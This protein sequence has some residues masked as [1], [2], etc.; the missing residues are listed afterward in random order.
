M[1][2]NKAGGNTNEDKMTWT[3]LELSTQGQSSRGN[4]ECTWLDSNPVYQQQKA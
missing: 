2:H 1:T 4:D 3:S